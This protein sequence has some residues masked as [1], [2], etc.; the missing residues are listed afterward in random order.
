MADPDPLLALVHDL[1]SPLMVVDGFATLLARDDG[2]LSAEQRADFAE[3]IRAAAADMRALL[4]S[5]VPE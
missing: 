2:S 1:R 3:R 5:A 4:D